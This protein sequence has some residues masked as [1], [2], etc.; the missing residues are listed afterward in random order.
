MNIEKHPKIPISN[1]IAWPP[2]TTMDNTLWGVLAT[3]ARLQTQIFAFQGS[4]LKFGE[5]HLNLFF[6]S[7][8]VRL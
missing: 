8:Q 1:I 6:N 3:V 4:D 7:V 5:K 2:Y